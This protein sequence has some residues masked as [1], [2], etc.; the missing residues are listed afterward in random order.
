MGGVELFVAT[1]VVAVGLA[2][3]TVAAHTLRAAGANLV[4]ALREE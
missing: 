4:D 3:L 2:A 1:A